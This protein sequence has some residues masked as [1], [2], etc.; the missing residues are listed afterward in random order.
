M[1]ILIIDNILYTPYISKIRKYKENKKYEE[2]VLLVLFM[3]ST[4]KKRN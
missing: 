1:F 3:D 2:N 4:R